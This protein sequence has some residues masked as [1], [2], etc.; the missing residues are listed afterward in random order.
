MVSPSLLFLYSSLILN[1]MKIVLDPSVSYQEIQSIVEYMTLDI[2]RP[3]LAKVRTAVQRSMRETDSFY[4]AGTVEGYSILI[5]VSP[6]KEYA[7]CLE[8]L[9]IFAMR[10]G[11]VV[12]A[13]RSGSMDHLPTP[14]RRIGPDLLDAICF[15]SKDR[16]M[17]KRKI[18][19][20]L[21]IIMLGISHEVEKHKMALN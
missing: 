12:R 5:R 16:K 17:V 8:S 10:G 14:F 21:H 1:T 3:E 15:Y 20:H 11:E 2:T 9:D 6:L 4:H 18:R 7:E 13:I 19:E